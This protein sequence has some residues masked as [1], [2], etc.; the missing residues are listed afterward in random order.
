[1]NGL[2]KKILKIVLQEKL[3]TAQ[4]KE[5]MKQILKIHL[6]PYLPNL[7][8]MKEITMIQIL[9]QSPNLLFGYDREYYNKP[10]M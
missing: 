7:H 10:I 3:V 1:M 9:T 2:K 8:M 6:L 4:W 5:E